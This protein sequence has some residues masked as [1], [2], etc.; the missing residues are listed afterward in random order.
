MQT[1]G[2]ERKK[3]IPP[4]AFELCVSVDTV[5]WKFTN[6]LYHFYGAPAGRYHAPITLPGLVSS[7]WS[8]KIRPVVEA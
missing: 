7:T 6:L 4:C 1:H 3:Q 5:P 8:W 2:I